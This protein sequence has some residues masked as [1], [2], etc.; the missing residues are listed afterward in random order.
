MKEFNDG[1]LQIRQGCS[2]SQD[3]VE[4]IRELHAKIKQAKMEMVMFF[5]SSHYDLD[6]M[7]SEI[8]ELFT[9]PVIGCTTAGELGPNGFTEF[10][11]TGVSFAGDVQAKSYVLDLEDC[12]EEAKRVGSDIGFSLKH[13]GSEKCFAVLLVDGLSLAEEHLAAALYRELGD[14]PIIGGSAGDDLKFD[15]TY[16]FGDGNFHTGKAVFATFRTH[17]EFATIKFQHFQPSDSILIVTDS[18]PANRVVREINGLPAVEV[19]AAELGVSVSDFSPSLFANHPLV[20]SLNGEVYVRSI[21]SAN[22]D[23]SMTL[24]CAIENGVVL[25][26]G[27][28]I[29]PIETANKAFQKVFDKIGQPQ[30]T[31]GSNCILRRLE[32]EQKGLIDSMSKIYMTNNVVGFNTY[33]EQWDAVHVNQ[34]FAGIAIGA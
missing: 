11:V 30:L 9:C 13:D 22:P 23:G 12:S 19:Y 33:G 31:I 20:L 24:F 29:D 8:N 5:C 25:S 28:A 32:F 17:K 3:A 10:S 34:T 18:D 4:A 2:Q 6:L 7:Q 27:Q 15:K 16:V 14:V 1:P 26:I 21:Q